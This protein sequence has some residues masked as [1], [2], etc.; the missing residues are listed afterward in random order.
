[1]QQEIQDLLLR[2]AHT[3][4]ELSRLQR[5]VDGAP[6]W[7]P[8]ELVQS[9]HCEAGDEGVSAMSATPDP[10]VMSEAFADQYQRRSPEPNIVPWDR[11]QSGQEQADQAAMSAMSATP[12]PE[13]MSENVTGPRHRHRTR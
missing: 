4:R 12:D 2:K 9:D 7:L 8:W 1:M 3:L 11:G 5:L 13:V 10:E 6:N